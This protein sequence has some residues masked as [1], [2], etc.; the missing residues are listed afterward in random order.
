MKESMPSSAQPAHAAQKPRTW[1]VVR[2]GI[3]I[4]VALSG[5]DLRVCPLDPYPKGRPGGLP[6]WDGLQEHELRAVPLVVAAR[7]VLR[8]TFRDVRLAVKAAFGN[9]ETAGRAEG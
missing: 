4:T 7:A 9:Q 3:Q 1:L 8:L 6:H 2:D 5:V